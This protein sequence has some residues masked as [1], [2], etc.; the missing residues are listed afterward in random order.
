MWETWPTPEDAGQRW[1][2]SMSHPFQGAMAHW[3]Y[4]GL[5]GIRP[6]PGGAGFREFR[7]Q[8]VMIP[9]LTHVKCRERT[10]MGW[11]GSEWRRD[12][13]RV[14]WEIEVPPGARAEVMVPGKRVESSGCLQGLAKGRAT[15]GAGKGRVV[16]ELK[17]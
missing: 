16:F 11:V 2:K 8:P 3:F 6:N 9:Y 14:T 15:A 5:A 10:A 7:L 12:G 17:N 1:P 4:S 13:K